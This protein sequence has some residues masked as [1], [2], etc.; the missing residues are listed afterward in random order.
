M[1]DEKA[2]ERKKLSIQGRETLSIGNNIDNS[3]TSSRLNPG[4]LKRSFQIET[5]RKRNV[6]SGL[7]KDNFISQ[8][9]INKS[10]NISQGSLTIEERTARINAIKKQ[11]QSALESEKSDRDSIEKKQNPK[12]RDKT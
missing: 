10:S 6:R 4:G 9:N 1:S 5:R 11:N 7:E 3:R 8:N 2:H 12:N